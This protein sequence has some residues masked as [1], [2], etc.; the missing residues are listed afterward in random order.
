MNRTGFWASF[1]AFLISGWSNTASTLGALPLD[2][3]PFGMPGCTLRTSI[4]A[5]T[6]LVGAGG[7]AVFTMAIPNLASLV[8]AT[9]HQ[10]AMVLDPGA[11][12]LGAVLSDAAT[13]VVGS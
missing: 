12:T 1:A 5:V 7:Q 9:F 4:D 13:A 11:N 10:Q 3:T 8:G 2:A 6:F